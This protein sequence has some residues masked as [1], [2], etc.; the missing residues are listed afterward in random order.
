MIKPTLYEIIWKYQTIKFG[1]VTLKVCDYLETSFPWLYRDE[2]V[3]T[4][5]KVVEE[6]AEYLQFI[7]PE[8]YKFIVVEKKY[9]ECI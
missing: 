3:S 6:T 4:N 5:K 7:S 1:T 2:V 8:D 9:D